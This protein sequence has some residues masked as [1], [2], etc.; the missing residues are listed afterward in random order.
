LLKSEIYL[1]PAIS[2]ERELALPLYPLH[3]PYLE[4]VKEEISILPTTSNGWYG[5]LTNPS[6]MNIRIPL[7]L[8]L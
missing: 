5:G 8:R 7:I 4:F 3:H 2:S 1:A 6:R